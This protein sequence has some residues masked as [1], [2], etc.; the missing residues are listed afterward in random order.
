VLGRL[1]QLA[2]EFELVVGART[3]ERV[4]YANFLKCEINFAGPLKTPKDFFLLM[5]A[6]Y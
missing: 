2:E 3:E 1:R 6:F 4:N 5:K